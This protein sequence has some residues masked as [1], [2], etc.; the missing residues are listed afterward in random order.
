[1][2]IARANIPDWERLWDDCV[3]N[4]IRKSQNGAVKHEDVDENVAL[5]AKGM[6]GKSKK[7]AFTSGSKEKGTQ[8]QEGKEKDYSK[9][10]CWNCQKMGH[11]AVMCLEKK[12]KGKWVA[13]AAKIEEFASSFQE[14]YLIARLAMSVSFSRGWYIDSG[15]SRHMTGDPIQC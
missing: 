4:D 8:K 12:K 2:V 3:Q 5:A 6:K 10:K 9:V 11:Y 13:A 14:F 15:A 7:G 1:M